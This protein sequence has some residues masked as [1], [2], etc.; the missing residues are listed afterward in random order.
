MFKPTAVFIGRF[1]PFHNGHMLVLEGMT[2]VCGK[3]FIGIGSSEKSRTKENP[4]SLAE[5]KEMI[6]RALQGKDLIPMFDIHMIDLPD[7]TD[8][9]V[10]REKVLEVSGPV[11]K[12]WTGNE[13]TK[14]CFEGY[15]E[16][17][18]IR[19]VPGIS[20]IDIR[21]KMYSNGDWQD[22]VPKEVVSFISEFDLLNQIKQI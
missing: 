2:K 7:E 3:I 20:G 1:Q 5:R 4:F 8:D 22:L 17:Q 12:V 13:R 16:V 21:D 6:Q 9:D 11:D 15:V 18:N 10:W 14:K 19:E